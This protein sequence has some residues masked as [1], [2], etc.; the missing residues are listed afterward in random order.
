MLVAFPLGSLFVGSSLLRYPGGLPITFVALGLG[1]LLAGAVAILIPEPP[2]AEKPVDPLKEGFEGCLFL[3]RHPVMRR[4]S[5]NFALVSATTFFVYWF[6][7]TVTRE[8]GLPAGANGFLADRS[9][10]LAMVVL[11]G[12]TLLFGSLARLPPPA[13]E[14]FRS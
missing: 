8:T 1:F 13:D 14:G 10:H 3:I 5:V 7:Q 9:A 12:L 11:G 6:Y 2:R 4:Y